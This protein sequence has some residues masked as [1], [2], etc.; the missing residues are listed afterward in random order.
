MRDVKHILILFYLLIDTY[1]LIYNF[2]HLFSL[3][4][5]TVCYVN[6]KKRKKNVSCP[7]YNLKN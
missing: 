1:G 7:V 4:Y 5:K 2:I 6:I 3:L